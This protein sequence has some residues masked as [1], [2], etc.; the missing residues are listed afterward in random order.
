LVA[1]GRY[2]FGLAD[3]FNQ[4]RNPEKAHKKQINELFSALGLKPE[5][6]SL[7]AGD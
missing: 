1:G 6:S 5:N 3:N 4:A 2:A 7:Y